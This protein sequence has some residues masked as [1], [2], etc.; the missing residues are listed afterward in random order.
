MIYIGLGD[1]CTRFWFGTAPQLVV[2]M[3]LGIYFIKSFIRGMFTSERKVVLWHS[4]RIAI[5]I[6]LKPND[7]VNRLQDTQGNSENMADKSIKI[8]I[9]CMARQTVIKPRTQDH[10]VVATK[11]CKI[12]VIELSALLTNR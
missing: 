6:N 3:L 10:I 5:R 1:L 12:K 9:L 11:V 2:D 8:C 4:P 7:N